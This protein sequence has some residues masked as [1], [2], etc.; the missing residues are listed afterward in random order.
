MAALNINDSGLASALARVCGGEPTEEACA[1]LEALE[2]WGCKDLSGLTACPRLVALVVDGSELTDLEPLAGLPALRDLAIRSSLVADLSALSRC[3][4]LRSLDLSYSPVRDLGVVEALLALDRITLVG[5]PLDDAGRAWAAR[6]GAQRVR[7]SP[8]PDWRLSRDL[9]A[10]GAGVLFGY[11][12]G[13][14][15]LVRPGLARGAGCQVDLV[16]DVTGGAVRAVMQQ[17]A[18]RP[19]SVFVKVKAETGGPRVGHPDEGAILVEADATTAQGWVSEAAPPGALAD[20][21]RS[22]IQGFPS[23]VWF[24]ST[25]QAH[26][27]F[28]EAYGA[29]FPAW[30]LALRAAVAGVEPQQAK[31][32]HL[33]WPLARR[34]GSEWYKISPG[35]SVHGAHPWLASQRHL[36]VVAEGVDGPG[37][38]LAV[39]A[40]RAEDGGVVAFTLEP[41][42]QQVLADPV[43]DSYAS[44]LDHIDQIRLEDGTIINRQEN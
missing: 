20:A 28:V 3:G 18:A 41:G 44:L 38:L 24:H 37:T 30:Y 43:F 25:E 9:W 16:A 7:L 23:L 27:R 10:L 40:E 14:H 26:K 22:L 35:L 1:G 34:G 13:R 8:E 42:S 2:V 19:A 33:T 21:Q 17:S 31:W 29:L 11:H 5:A 12:G 36:A 32:Y 39:P 4:A 15:I 6:L